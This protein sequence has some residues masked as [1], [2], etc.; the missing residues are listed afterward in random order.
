ML[1]G[2]GHTSLVG[3]KGNLRGTS[4]QRRVSVFFF[5]SAWLQTAK[6]CPARAAAAARAACDCGVES[7]EEEAKHLESPVTSEGTRGTVVCFIL[8]LFLWQL[9]QNAMLLVWSFTSR[10]G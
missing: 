3:S 10:S 8:S 7:I 5:L 6:P 4:A 9:S 2:L 1:G